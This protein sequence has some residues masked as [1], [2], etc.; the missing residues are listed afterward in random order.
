M[1]HPKVGNSPRKPATNP[2]NIES[3]NQNLAKDPFNPL[4]INSARKLL[5]RDGGGKSAAAAGSRSNKKRVMP[6]QEL[7]LG[8]PVGLT[9]GTFNQSEMRVNKS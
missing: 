1:S 8:Y 3:M 5:D 4:L 2:F 9:Q 6:Q 7:S